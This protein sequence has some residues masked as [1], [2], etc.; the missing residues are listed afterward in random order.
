MAPFFFFDFTLDKSAMPPVE[1]I[2]ETQPLPKRSHTEQKNCCPYPI[3]KIEQIVKDIEKAAYAVNTSKFVSDLFECGAIAISNAVDLAQKDEREERY[4]QIIRG[5][6]PTQQRSLVDIFGKVFALLSSVVYDNG[7]FNDNL[8]EI[9]MSCGLINKHTAQFFTPYSASV[10]AAR[11]N[12]DETLV[13]E[14]TADDRILTVNDP[15]CGG[16]GMLIAALEALKS[17]GVNYA[18]NC[19]MEANDVDLRCVHMTYLQL[20]L[21]GVPA[22][23]RHQNTLTRECWSVWYTP[24]YLFQYLRFRKF[25][26]P[27]DNPNFQEQRRTA[28]ATA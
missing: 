3:P 1:D 20:A 6:R 25:D 13:K 12:I 10:L 22:I 8:G 28:H 26:N 24:A 27:Y 4:L 15:C 23:V 14:K 5:Y 16:G 2:P 18:R 19:F 7:R 21:A 9:F 17:L 11:I